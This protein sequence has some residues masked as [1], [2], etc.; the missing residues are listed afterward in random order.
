VSDEVW[1][2]R[3]QE[4]EKERSRVIRIFDT[5]EVRLVRPEPPFVVFVKVPSSTFESDPGF[6]IVEMSSVVL[7]ELDKEETDVSRGLDLS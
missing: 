3:K 5:Q 6:V 1:T 2:E 4:R 7:E